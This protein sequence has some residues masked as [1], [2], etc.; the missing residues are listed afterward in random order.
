MKTGG[1]FSKTCCKPTCTS[2]YSLITRRHLISHFDDGDKIKHSWMGFSPLWFSD[3]PFEAPPPL[4]YLE[5]LAVQ[6]SDVAD[7]PFT[8]LI[9][10][11]IVRSP[12]RHQNMLKGSFTKIVLCFLCCLLQ[13]S[14]CSWI[15]TAAVMF[16]NSLKMLLTGGKT[17]RKSR[18]SGECVCWCPSQT[19]TH[20]PVSCRRCRRGLSVYFWKQKNYTSFSKLLAE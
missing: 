12:H 6:H 14:F 8:W 17:N 3:T 20:L 5:N 9:L 2:F 19:R 4:S 7:N 16:R 11:L 15:S 18:S 13:V 10:L 1:S